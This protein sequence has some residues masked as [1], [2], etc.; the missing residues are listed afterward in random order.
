[1]LQSAQVRILRWLSQH[2]VVEWGEEPRVLDDDS[3]DPMEQLSAAA[4][5]GR[6]PAG[7]AGSATRPGDALRERAEV[8][9]T[10]ALLAGDGG[11]SRTSLS[12]NNLPTPP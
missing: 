2:G 6:V 1:V 9:V 8:Q 10:G 4:V 3:E 5:S 11:S 12:T 7:P